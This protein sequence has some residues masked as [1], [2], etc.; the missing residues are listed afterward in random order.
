MGAV[1][2]IDLQ[3]LSSLQRRPCV[4]GNDRDSAQR[5][6]AVGWFKRIDGHRL[7]DAFHGQC[8]LVIHAADG[9]FRLHDRIVYL[10]GADG[11]RTERLF[12]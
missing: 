4:V 5:L 6:E 9:A 1:V 8:I 11:W 7:L 3:T 10:Q 12:P 2:P